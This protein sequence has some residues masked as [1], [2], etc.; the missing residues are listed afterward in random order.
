MVLVLCKS[1]TL[2]FTWQL[3]T[4]QN[5]L[6]FSDQEPPYSMITLHEMAETG[7]GTFCRHAESLIRICAVLNSPCHPVPTVWFFFWRSRSMDYFHNCQV[8]G[9]EAAQSAG[10]SGGW[11]LL[12][13]FFFRPSHLWRVLWHLCSMW[14][15]SPDVCRSFLFFFLFSDKNPRVWTKKNI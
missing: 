2:T 8:L 15:K 13:A 14:T 11:V 6:F 7:K 9:E 12:L 10:H 4:L 5:L 1:C 3:F